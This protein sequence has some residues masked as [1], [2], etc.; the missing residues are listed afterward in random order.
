[1]TKRCKYELCNKEFTPTNAQQLY[2]CPDHTV[3]QMNLKAKRKR[4]ARSRAKVFETKPCEYCGT[5]FTPKRATQKYC[6]PDCKIKAG[7]KK[8]KEETKWRNGQTKTGKIDPYYLRRGN[9]SNQPF[10]YTGGYE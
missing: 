8:G 5:Y 9:I 4:A 3:K 6:Q 7:S 1:M 2:C 10:A